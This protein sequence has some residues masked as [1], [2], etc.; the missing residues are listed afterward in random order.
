VQKFSATILGNRYDY[1]GT[2]KILVR[3]VLKPWVYYV[4]TAVHSFVARGQAPGSVGGAVLW[5][6]HRTTRYVGF[7][8]RF[9]LQ[10]QL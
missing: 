4:W 2:P 6:T 5:P 8:T 3:F 1:G 9:P 7:E 10:T